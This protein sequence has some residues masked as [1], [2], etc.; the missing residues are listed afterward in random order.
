[1]SY[2]FL[3]DLVVALHVAYVSFVVVGE[4]AILLGWLCRW[5]WVRSPW[6][7]LGH[8]LAIAIVAVESVF[9]IT[10]P[11]TILEDRLRSWSGQEVTE[12]TFIGR[13]LH[14]LLFYNAPTWVFTAAYIGFA[15]LVLLTW[16]L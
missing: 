12:G 6:F 8:L 10:C 16:I 1:M 7:R 3:A 15:M 5:G 13:A 2:A 4:L 11:L 14:N 9:K